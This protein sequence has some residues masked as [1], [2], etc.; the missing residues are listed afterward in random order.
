MTD[1]DFGP[2]K[3]G[4]FEKTSD[5]PGKTVGRINA[6]GDSHTVVFDE[7]RPHGDDEHASPVGYMFSSLVACQ[8]SVLAQCFEK[9]RIEEYEIE[10]DA[11]IDRRGSD[12]VAEEMPAHTAKRIEH[13]QI[14]LSVEVPEEFEDRARRCLEVYDQGCIVGQS[15]R[16]GIEYT[17]ETELTVR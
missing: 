14:D 13:V 4:H 8:M 3:D 15:F 16:A 1:S 17:P 12:E 2:P 11:A 5:A 6:T 9:S 7:P 10:A